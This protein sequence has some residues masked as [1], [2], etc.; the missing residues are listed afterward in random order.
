MTG[1]TAPQMLYEAKIVYEAIASADAP[2][3]TSRQ[4]SVLLTQAQENIIME[5][6]KMG[7]DFDEFNRRLSHKL[8]TEKTISIAAE[9]EMGE[10]VILNQPLGSNSYEVPLETDYLHIVKDTANSVV[11]VRPVS[12]DFYHTNI[13]NPFENPTSDEFWRLTGKDSL[14]II[15]DGSPLA[16]YHLIYLRRPKPIIVA[17]LPEDKAIEGHYLQTDCELDHS[18]HRLIVN[19]AA[20]LAHAYTGNQ[21]GYQIQSIESTQNRRGL[22]A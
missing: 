13:D 5:T 4:W 9:E 17:D 18:V 14:I 12:Y 10:T 1:L 21:L 8:L 19:E 6:R 16:K 15:T 7:F 11:R 2:G 20:K 22:R 3:Y